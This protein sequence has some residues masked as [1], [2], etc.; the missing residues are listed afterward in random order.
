[1]AGK[2]LGSLP[3]TGIFV[4]RL[5]LP[6]TVRMHSVEIRVDR[7]PRTSVK[8]TI[9]E[10]RTTMTIYEILTWLESLGDDARRHH[11][12]RLLISNGTSVFSFFFRILFGP[13][14]GGPQYRMS[15]PGQ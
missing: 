6:Y 1:M 3:G 2:Y 12:G 14:V 13:M 9:E 15:V 8:R 7:S 11:V 4:S 5:F 10:I